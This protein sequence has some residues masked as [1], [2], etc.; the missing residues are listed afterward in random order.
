MSV[1]DDY[2]SDSN[3]LFQSALSSIDAVEKGST[4]Q[5]PMNSNPSNSTPTEMKCPDS[6]D[7]VLVIRDMIFV[8][9]GNVSMQVG[10]V[11]TWVGNVGTWVGNVGLLYLGGNINMQVGTCRYVIR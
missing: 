9:R 4:S 11:G 2:Q 3:E 7:A 8:F 6:V 1:H 5:D 10:S